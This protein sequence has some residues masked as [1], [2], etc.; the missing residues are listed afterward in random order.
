MTDTGSTAAIVRAAGFKGVKT[1]AT[2]AN[3]ITKLPIK[4]FLENAPEAF[5]RKIPAIKYP[6]YGSRAIQS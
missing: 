4:R 5:P 6:R 2:A 1:S 3:V